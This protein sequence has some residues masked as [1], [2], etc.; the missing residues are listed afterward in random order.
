MLELKKLRLENGLKRSEFARLIGIHQNTIANYENGICEAPYDTLIK[1]ADFFDITIDE[2]LG[3]EK[4][5][6]TVFN[7]AIL[8]VREKNMLAKYRTLSIQNKSRADDFIDV[9]IKANNEDN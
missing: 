1:F 3:R 4:V 9:L 2:L 7:A 6:T 8:T 5:D